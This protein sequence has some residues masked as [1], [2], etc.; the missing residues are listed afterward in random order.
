[1]AM[2]PCDPISLAE[3]LFKKE[4]Q[5]DD[6]VFVA[7]RNSRPLLVESPL[8]TNDLSIG[9]FERCYVRKGKIGRYLLLQVTLAWG[10]SEPLVNVGSILS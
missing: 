6:S 3:L 10:K 2:P 1:M 4:V 9:I 8:D 7:I 5:T